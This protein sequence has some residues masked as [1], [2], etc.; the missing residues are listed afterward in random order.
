MASILWRELVPLRN[1]FFIGRDLFSGDGT[2]SI[3]FAL[4]FERPPNTVP[5]RLRPPKPLFGGGAGVIT[6]LVLR[7]NRVGEHI[8][9]RAVEAVGKGLGFSSS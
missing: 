8:P 9:V 4:L 1:G 3:A 6:V 2:W 7:S 5:K